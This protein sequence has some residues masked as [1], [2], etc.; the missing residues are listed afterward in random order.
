MGSP[1]SEAGRGVGEGPHHRVTIGYS[2]AVGV[3][4]VTFAEWDA[5]VGAGGLWGPSSG[6]L[7]LGPWPPTGDER[8]L[9]GRAGVRAVVVAGDGPAV[10]AVDGGGVGVRGAGGDVDGSLLGAGRGRAVPVCEWG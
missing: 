9:G 5:C 7:R 3:Y 2:L 4:E 1:A 6:R 8:E 10:P